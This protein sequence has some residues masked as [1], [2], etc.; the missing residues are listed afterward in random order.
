MEQTLP[1]P[2]PVPQLQ[3]LLQQLQN[4]I[5]QLTRALERADNARETAE[6][7]V[8]NLRLALHTRDATIEEMQKK[9][10]NPIIMSEERRSPS[11]TPNSTSSA[12]EM[13]NRQLREAIRVR[14]LLIQD[15]KREKVGEPSPSRQEQGQQSLVE[16]VIFDK[17]QSTKA[18]EHSERSRLEME[19]QFERMKHSQT[20]ALVVLRA[21]CHDAEKECCDIRASYQALVKSASSA[22][23]SITVLKSE[24]ASVREERDHAVMANALLRREITSSQSTVTA[25]EKHVMELLE[26]SYGMVHSPVR[27]QAQQIASSYKEV[28]GGVSPVVV[29]RLCSELMNADAL[30]QCLRMELAD[31]RLATPN[32]SRMSM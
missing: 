11:Q 16:M 7:E 3:Q 20:R 25:L 8:D 1:S 14:D 2:S 5:T 12:Y 29:E 32:S 27:A 31:M 23:A 22:D 30:A 24:L 13:E 21:R 18:L 9:M 15:L 19:E 10:A 4:E 17:T 26:Q 6:C 28:H